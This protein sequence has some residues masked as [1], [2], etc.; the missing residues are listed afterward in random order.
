MESTPIEQIVEIEGAKQDV[1]ADHKA[2]RQE[3]CAQP[4][5]KTEVSANQEENENYDE[6]LFDANDHEEAKSQAN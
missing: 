4:E 5:D 6:T 1:E 2:S 3:K